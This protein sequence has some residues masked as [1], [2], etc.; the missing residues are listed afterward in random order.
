[1]MGK[2][3]TLLDLGCGTRKK[4]G[5][6]GVDMAKLDGVDVICNFESGLPFKDGAIDGIYSNFLFEPIAD[7]VHLFEEIYR[8][9]RNGALVKFRVPY[10]QSVTQYKDPTHRAVITPDTIRYF[11]GDTWYGSDY[12]INTR[13]KLLKL[14]YHYMPPFSPLSSKK[15]FF[16][17]PISYPILLFAR[18]FLW[19]IVHSITIEMVAVK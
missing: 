19:N 3:R 17:W 15:L 4:D 7:T 10:Y 5:H 18:R 11:S 9:C 16:L 8:I 14:N 2:S 1:M 12:N 13:F 6:I